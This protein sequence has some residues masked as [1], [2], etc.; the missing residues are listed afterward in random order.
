MEVEE[1]CPFCALDPEFV[2]RVAME[3]E[4]CLYLAGTEPV[5]TGSGLIIPKAH[6]PTV[7]DLTPEEWSATFELLQAAK[8]ALTMELHPDGFNVGWNCGL[9]GG[10]AIFH[11]HLHVIPRFAD[12]PLAGKGLRYWLKSESNRRP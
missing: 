11:A 3:N 7:F 6:R 4:W 1:R 5:L 8:E 2:S 12:E 9:V 10:Q